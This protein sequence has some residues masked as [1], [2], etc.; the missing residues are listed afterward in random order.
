M[1][2]VPVLAPICTLVAA[3]PK[4]I[5]VAVVSIKLNVESSVARVLPFT[6]SVPATL[7]VLPTLTLPPVDSKPVPIWNVPLP[8]IFIPSPL[9]NS[10]SP[11]LSLVPLPPVILRL[12]VSVSYTHLRAHET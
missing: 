9:L 7:S 8:L 6:L 1:V 3:P 11:V 2:V 4:L 12:P 10:K 5:V